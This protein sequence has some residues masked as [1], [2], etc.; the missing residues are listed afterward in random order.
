MERQKRVWIGVVIF[1][2]IFHLV[3]IIGLR[4]ELTSGLFMRLIPLNLLLSL[5]M[6]ANFHRNWSPFF[7][8]FCLVIFVAGWGVEVLGVQTGLLFGEYEYGAMLGPGLFG[9]P[10]MM[11]VNWLLLIYMIGHVTVLTGASRWVRITLGAGLMVLMDILIEPF[12][13]RFDMWHWVGDVIPF[14][15][16]LAWFLISWVMMRYFHA[17]NVEKPNPLAFPLLLIQLVF[18]A[19]FMI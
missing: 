16:Y 7:R 3:G 2:V 17:H 4:M 5:G 12:A 10:F 18:F 19:S 11:G 9:V 13:I 8:I 6:L 15:N 1:L 14:Q